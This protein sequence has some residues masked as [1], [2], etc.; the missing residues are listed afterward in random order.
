MFMVIIQAAIVGLLDMGGDAICRRNRGDTGEQMTAIAWKEWHE[1]SPLLWIALGVFLGLPIIGGLE[2]MVTGLGR[3]HFEISTEPGVLG[4]GGVFAIFVKGRSYLPGF[5]S[6][7][8]DFWRSRP[9]LGVQ[10]MLVKFI[11]GLAIVLASLLIPLL[12]AW[13]LDR[14]FD[15]Q[16]EMM[17]TLPVIWC[18]FYCIDF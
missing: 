12:A 18:L 5:E 2:Y 11:I 14:T 6:E 7:I 4:L 1:N 15:D 16:R 13:L 9:V 10:W 3:H 17:K 8:E